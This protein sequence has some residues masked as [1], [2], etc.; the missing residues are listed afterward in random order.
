[1]LPGVVMPSLSS[2][3]LRGSGVLLG[4]ECR[5]W[6]VLVLFHCYI[7]VFDASLETAPTLGMPLLCFWL[8][9]QQR[10]SW[11]RISGPAQLPRKEM[12]WMIDD[13]CWV[14]G[15]SI[16]KMCLRRPDDMLTCCNQQNQYSSGNSNICSESV[17]RTADQPALVRY[18][19]IH[20]PT[21]L[22][23][24]WVPGSVQAPPV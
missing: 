19:P 15:S 10:A 18:P 14:T 3:K 21:R 24:L 9:D 5:A 1:M 23:K 13:G 8:S 2:K 7:D 17:S 4:L 12:C 20:L 11:C 16:A 22:C 6:V